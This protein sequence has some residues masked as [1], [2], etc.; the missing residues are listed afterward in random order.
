[1]ILTGLYVGALAVAA[2]QL[3]R[4]REPRLVPLVV[5]LVL[6]SVV[7]ARGRPDHWATAAHA[8]AALAGLVLALVVPPRPGR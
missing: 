7:H 8:A 2:V 1:M 5:M 4:W 6:L 3:L